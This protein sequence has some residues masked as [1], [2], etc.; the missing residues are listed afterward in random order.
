MLFVVSLYAILFLPD[1]LDQLRGEVIARAALRRELVP[2]LPRPLVLPERGPSTAAAARVVARGGGAVL[3]VLA[4][5]PDA[6]PHGVG[7]ERTRAAHRRARRGRDL[8]ARDGDPVPPLHRSV[9]RRTTAPTRASPRCCSG[10]RSRSCGR[11]GG[12]S[13]ARV[14]TRASCS[15]RSRC[16]SGHRAVLDVPQRRGVRSRPLPR[17]VPAGRRSS[18][19]SSSRRPCTR[20]RSSCRGCSGSRCSAGSACAPTAS[21]CGTGRSTWSPGRTPTC[22]SPGIPLLVLR[23][24]LTFGAAALS[25]KYVEEPIRHGAIER[26][27]AQLPRVHRPRSAAQ[28]R[29][30]GFVLVAAGIGVGLRGHRGRSRQRRERRRARRA[31]AKQTAGRRAPGDTTTTSARARPPRRR[32]VHHHARRRPGSPPA[33]TAI[34]DSV[35]LGA[36]NQLIATIDT[37]FGTRHGPA[38]DDR[39]R[40]REPAVLDR[41]RRRSRPAR[42]GRARSD[43]G[44]AARHQRHHRPRRLRPADG[45]PR[46]P[47]EGRDRQRQG[48]AARGSSRS[49]TR[50]PPGV[51]K[52][53]NAV[54][55]DW[56]GYGGA[57]PEFFYDDGIHLRPE[58]AD[59]LRPVRGPGAGGGG[60]P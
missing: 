30:P 23:L 55:L 5:H 47:A 24:A 56:H 36:A 39:R 52:Y 3:P 10:R 59:G 7:Q 4:A 20:R 26:R 2:H 43:R 45:D 16:G 32:P 48:A 21:T 54:L 41:G 33:V 53:K 50:S 58:G 1:V 46:R 15:T 6:G 49:T 28:A 29:R 19:R 31:S 8:H 57:H 60:S 25:Y 13:D 27:W 11:R 22:R 35:M 40:G 17:R 37:M 9:A 44:R 14:A 12:S 18:R 42:T 51:K 34:G 38:G